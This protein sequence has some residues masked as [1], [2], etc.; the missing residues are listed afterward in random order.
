MH[1]SPQSI[2]PPWPTTAAIVT[3]FEMFR[4]NG[5]CGATMSSMNCAI[6]FGAR[7][8]G[9]GGGTRGKGQEARWDGGG[10]YKRMVDGF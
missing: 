6:Q 9:D 10:R 5:Q 8:K 1:R 2:T 4:P 3:L 7:G